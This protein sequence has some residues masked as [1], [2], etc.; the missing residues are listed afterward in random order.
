MAA[1]FTG[2]S[3]FWEMVF[4]GSVGLFLGQ[5]EGHDGADD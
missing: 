5:D 4:L 2:Q 1:W 3:D